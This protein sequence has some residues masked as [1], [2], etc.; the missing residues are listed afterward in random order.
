MV[1]AAGLHLCDELGG[2]RRQEGAGHLPL[3]HRGL[4]DVARAA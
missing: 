3:A 2:D 1:A 4:Q